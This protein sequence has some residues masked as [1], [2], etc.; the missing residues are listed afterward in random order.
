MLVGAYKHSI[1]NKNR[2]F[3]PVKFRAALGH[4]CVVSKDIKYKCLRLYSL[5]RWEEYTEKIETLP[6]IAMSDVR[7]MIY[8]NSDDVDPDSQG[9]I[10]LNQRICADVGL[11][12]AKEVMVT[13]A[14]THAQIWQ[15]EEWE[16]FKEQMDLEAKQKSVIEELEKAGF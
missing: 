9:R 1:D 7:Q 14:H 12:G 8:H 3:I 15:V 5:E 2:L 4:T 11:A 6:T 13:G 10:I 16:N